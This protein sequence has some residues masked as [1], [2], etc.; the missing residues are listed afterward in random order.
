MNHI[1]KTLKMLQEK[2]YG[3]DV[4]GSFGSEDDEHGQE[5][6]RRRKEKQDSNEASRQE[7]LKEIA[8]HCTCGAGAKPLTIENHKPNCAAWKAMG[9]K[10]PVEK[11]K[12]FL[13]R[14]KGK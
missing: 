2:V 3:N 11:K 4:E 14:F 13:D 5:M 7:K 12:S 8:K 10:P 1:N 6:A 9:V